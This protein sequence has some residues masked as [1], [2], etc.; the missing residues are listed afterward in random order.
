MT[1]DIIMSIGFDKA[2]VSAL[3]ALDGRIKYKQSFANNRYA[4]RRVIDLELALKTLKA[5]PKSQNPWANKRRKVFANK[6]QRI[7]NERKTTHTD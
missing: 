1:S 4:S 5:K 6:I 7:I 2:E 3:F